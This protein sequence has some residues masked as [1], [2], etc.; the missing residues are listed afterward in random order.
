MIFFCKAIK[1]ESKADRAI[2]LIELVPNFSPEDKIQTR[3]I[4]FKSDARVEDIATI[5]DDGKQGPSGSRVV[6]PDRRFR[7]LEELPSELTAALT[8]IR[9]LLW[10]RGLPLLATRTRSDILAD[11]R[12]MAPF[13]HKLG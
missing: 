11:I 10:C 13:I 8:S 1:I 12:A 7:I 4:A 3:D 2:T 5:T 9:H 6:F